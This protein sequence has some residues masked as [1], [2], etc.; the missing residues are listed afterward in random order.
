[1]AIDFTSGPQRDESGTMS[2]RVFARANPPEQGH[3]CSQSNSLLQIIH[4][5]MILKRFTDSQHPVAFE[6][7][8]RRAFTAVDLFLIF[9]PRSTPESASGL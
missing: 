4:Q 5:T 7:R 1:M 8:G 9:V 3:G 6:A 2:G